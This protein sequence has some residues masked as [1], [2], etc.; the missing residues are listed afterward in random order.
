MSIHFEPI[1]TQNRELALNLQIAPEQHGFVESVAQCLN[2]AD[3]H[4]RWKPVGIYHDDIM[5]GF[6]MYGF[7]GW[8]YPPFGKLWL[9]RLLI[10]KTYQGNGYGKTALAGLINRLIEEYHCKKIYLSVIEEN[11]VAIALYQKFGFHFNGKK[12]IHN[13]LIMEYMVP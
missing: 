11:Q 12:D 10:D 13:E 1:T 7:F 8:K 3:H 5:I 9:D 2:E 6:S 4:R